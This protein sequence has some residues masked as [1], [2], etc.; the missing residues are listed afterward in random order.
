MLRDAAKFHL[1][2]DFYGAVKPSGRERTWPNEMTREAIYGRESGK[3]PEMHDAAL[4]FTRYVQGHADFT[5]VEF[6][7]S[8]LV[9]STWA[10]ELAQAVIYT[11]PFLCYG[12]SPKATYRIRLSTF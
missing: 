9:N 12:G 8:R 7:T 1:M 2:I 3:L 6:R 5:P 10:R 4:P 11:S